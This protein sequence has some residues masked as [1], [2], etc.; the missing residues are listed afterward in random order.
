[1]QQANISL[2]HQYSQ[3]TDFRQALIKGSDTTIEWEMIADYENWNNPF[4]Q[5]SD[6]LILDICGDRVNNRTYLLM[7]KNDRE[8]AIHLNSTWG[9]DEEV[10]LYLDNDNE[11]VMET[12]ELS[13]ILSENHCVTMST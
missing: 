2:E 9:Y 6:Q 11:G 10:F 8:V 7:I 3:N 13:G 1:M 4:A 5:N 12:F